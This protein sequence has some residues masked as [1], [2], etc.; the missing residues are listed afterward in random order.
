VPWDGLG[1][2]DDGDRRRQGHA[3]NGASC[4]RGHRSNRG[5]GLAASR[6]LAK[7]GFHV[8]LAVR[9]VAR[10]EA[11]ARELRAEIEGA[12]V[13]AMALD[14]SSIASVDAFVQAFR[15]R[16]LSL[17]LLLANAGLIAFDKLEKSAE[18]LEIQLATNHLGHF[19]LVTS[20]RDVLERSAPA[21]VVV[22]SSTMHIPGTGPGKG[23]PFD[24][25]NVGGEKFYDPMVFYRNSKLANVWF[26]YAMARRLEGTGV[27]VNALCPGFVPETAA[28]TAQG[29]QRVLFRWVFPLLPQART[30]EQGA[31]HMAWVCTAPELDGVSGKFFADQHERRSSDASYD[32]EAQER[33]FRA[34][35]AWVAGARGTTTRA[36]A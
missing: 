8:V 14:L 22:V 11:V 10:G 34:S 6:K 20:L 3:G 13:D 27:T 31:T 1:K 32:A 2:D 26:T 9:D 33:L 24:Y 4:R 35:E 5:L 7:A 16:G 12:E 23:P 19:H 25:E 17:H 36:A 15:A 28:P 30:V 29:L 18:G 21:R